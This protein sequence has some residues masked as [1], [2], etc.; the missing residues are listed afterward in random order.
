M[1]LPF[2]WLP[3]LVAAAHAARV[4]GGPTLAVQG[5][6][7]DGAVLPG[8]PDAR[9]DAGLRAALAGLTPTEAWLGEAWNDALVQPLRALGAALGEDDV[10]PA[11]EALLDERFV[12]RV[13]AERWLEREL[14]GRLRVREA[15]PLAS[16]SEPPPK[17]LEFQG[18]EGLAR[19]LADWRA[20]GFGS[21]GERPIEASVKLKTVGIQAGED[22]ADLALLVQWQARGGGGA[23]HTRTARFGARFEGRREAPRL[24]R[25]ELEGGTHVR[26]EAP[27]FRERTEDLLA[28]VPA[29]SWLQFGIDHWR[30]RLDTRLDVPVVGHPAGI[31]LG[32]LNGDGREDLVLAQPG[33]LPNLLLVRTPDGGFSDVSHEAGIDFLEFTRAVLV[34]DLDGDRDRDIVMFMGR[35][36]VFLENDGEAHFRIRARVEAPETT[37][38][39]AADFDG[40]DDLDLYACAYVSPYANDDVPLPYHDAENGQPNL[41]LR[42]DG[43]FRFVDVTVETGLGG[44][45]PGNRRFSFAASWEDYDDDGDQDLYVANDFGRNNLYRNDG[46]RF[47]DVAREAGVEDISAGMGVSWADFDG[48]GRMDLYVSNMFSS[49][50]HRVAFQRN[51]QP[52]ADEGERAALRRHSRGNSLF[53]NLGD[54]TFEDVSTQAGVTMGRWAWGALFCDWNDD[55]RPDLLVPNGFLTQTGPVD[56]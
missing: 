1:A 28:G 25:L 52:E 4:P 42:N 6:E 14:P 21:E 49:A 26:A 3:L 55:G 54:G 12:V 27:L 24:V 2:L 46:G 48:D 51:F 29:R 30:A 8:D 23:L 17:P 44:D 10:P 50:G 16:S 38:L 13:R 43:D 47:V 32:D 45:V 18:K 37:A 11:A 20:S 41:L 9:R 56:L 36:L 7:V 19:A 15:E 33:G 39:A 53:R 34:F 5:E 22:F 35:E 31:A 40:D